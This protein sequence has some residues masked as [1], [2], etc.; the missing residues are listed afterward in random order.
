TIFDKAIN[1]YNHVERRLQEGRA[2]SE[3]YPIPEGYDAHGYAMIM[4]N[5]SQELANALEAYGDGRHTDIRG[6]SARYMDTIMQRFRTQ[7]GFMLEMV[8][9]GQSAA[10]GPKPETLLARHVNPGH[11]L[12]C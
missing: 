3:P 10:T 6:R 2:R 8:P 7:E 9:H 11:T 1:L 12:E 4:L 5:V